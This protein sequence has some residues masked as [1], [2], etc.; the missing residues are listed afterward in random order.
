MTGR[1]LFTHTQAKR[2]GWSRE[3]PPDEAWRPSRQ[4]SRCTPS[5]E[6]NQAAGG[7]DRRSIPLANGSTAL[8]SICLRLP[9]KS[10]R[11]YAYLRWSE[12]GQTRER[13]VCEATAA[14]RAENLALAWECAHTKGLTASPVAGSAGSWAKDAA[15]RSV[16][17]ANKGRDTAPELALRRAVHALGLRYR[18]GQRP[19][20]SVRR[21]ADLVFKGARLAVFVDGCFWHGCSDHYR[22]STQ[23]SE[24]WQA[25]IEG[26][27]LRDKETDRKL[28]E[29]GWR[30]L[31]IWEHD[32]PA[33][34]A[35]RVA[36]LVLTGPRFD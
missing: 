32:D 25:K 31:R 4:D 2:R 29:G 24:F 14:T 22:P 7:R 12:Q 9:P 27:R 16:M 20:P 5:Q 10:R 30:V 33:L 6:Q 35:Q 28:Q 18:V 23:N 26:T 1:Q 21:T 13:Y 3:M 17:R 19:L 34:A 36:Q 15:V 11:I 8:A